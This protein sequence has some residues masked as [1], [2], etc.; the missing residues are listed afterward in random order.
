MDAELAQY[1]EQARQGDMEAFAYVV[2][3]YQPMVN[4]VL[5]RYLPAHARDDATQETFV[6]AWRGLRELRQI[7]AFAG[8]LA[9]VARSQA[10]RALRAP[11]AD[12][13]V[14]EPAARDEYDGLERA[15]VV[16]E[17]R[18][19]I[20][21]L[22]AA[23]RRVIERHYLEGRKLEEIAAQLGLP[24]GTVKRRLHEARQKL[25]RSLAGFDP[26]TGSNELKR[27][28]PL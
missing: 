25:R 3:A 12:L 2:A 18:R 8:W 15:E 4:G 5:A 23:H 21:G 22:G 24:L 28:F 6:A 7:Q 26:W 13:L 20:A 17:I 1:L 9:M 19:T 14:D 27:R 10:L 11:K 16:R